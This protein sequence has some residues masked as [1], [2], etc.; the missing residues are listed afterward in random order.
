MNDF[1]TA[2]T[3]A[4]GGPPADDPAQWG[5]RLCEFVKFKPVMLLRGAKKD[6]SEALTS[7]FYELSEMGDVL[8]P[9]KNS[10]LDDLYPQDEACLEGYA[11]LICELGVARVIFYS[12]LEKAASAAQKVHNIYFSIDNQYDVDYYERQYQDFKVLKDTLN[13]FYQIFGDSVVYLESKEEEIRNK[14]EE[15]ERLK[16]ER[17]P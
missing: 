8:C 16:Q 15:N 10:V 4:G 9:N 14:I 6:P 12:L 13:L 11:A 1:R 5:A 3:N 17:V 2:A 7:L